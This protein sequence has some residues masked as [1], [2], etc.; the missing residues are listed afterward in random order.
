MKKLWVIAMLL[1]P[2]VFGLVGSG[3][4]ELVQWSINGHSYE[5]V[6][7]TEA[8]WEQAKAH[9]EALGGHL[10]TI[11]SIEEQKFIEN[12]LATSGAQT[13]AYW[14][15]LIETITEGIY[16]WD[17]GESLSYTN[18]YPG[19]PD[20]AG[21]GWGGENRGHISWAVEPEALHFANRGQW[22]DLRAEGWDINPF[23]N[24]P[25]LNRAGYIVEFEGGTT[26]CYTQ[27][28]VD[29][30]VAQAVAEAVAGKDAT[31]SNLQQTISYL[32]NQVN[33]LTQQNQALQN[34]VNQLTTGLVSG[35]TNLQN[36]F[37]VVF[38]DPTF[39]IPGATPLEQYQNLINAIL[40][41]NKGRKEGIYTNLGGKPGKGPK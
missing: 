8:T 7:D 6:I 35:L 38:H 9:A 37:R 4:A 3:R 32:Q 39:V 16:T 29:E 34:Q 36:H 22:N 12:L 20:N 28:E 17:N 41:L 18:W 21:G 13:G 27:Q 26:H 40:N 24:Y 10:V 30:I 11:T 1:I 31:I 33:N 15:G 2:I 23:G 19:Q 25:D 5:V 14:I